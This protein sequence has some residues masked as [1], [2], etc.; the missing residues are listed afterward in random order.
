MI[1]G[2]TCCTQTYIDVWKQEI[3]NSIF[4][5]NLN[6]IQKKRLLNLMSLIKQMFKKNIYL[7]LQV[8]W[9]RENWP[10]SSEIIFFTNV[11]R[12]LRFEIKWYLNK[13]KE[14]K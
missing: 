14:S 1:L 8:Q 6:I 4:S 10:H 9:R 11:L 13:Y 5:N 3:I 12:C 2:L 7:V